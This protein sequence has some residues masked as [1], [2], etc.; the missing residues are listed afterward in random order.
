MREK[1]GEIKLY[2]WIHQRIDAEM[3]GKIIQEEDVD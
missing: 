3:V 1:V 2:I